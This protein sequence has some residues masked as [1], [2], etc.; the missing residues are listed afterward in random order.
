MSEIRYR[1]DLSKDDIE[2]HRPTTGYPGCRAAR[3]GAAYQYHI[4]E[5]KKTFEKYW[6]TR[7]KSEHIKQE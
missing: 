3:R 4:E 6:R 2:E 7:P 5:C 1:E